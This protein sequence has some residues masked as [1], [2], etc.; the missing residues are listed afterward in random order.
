MFGRSVVLFCLAWVMLQ[1]RK[2]VVVKK[3]LRQGIKYEVSVTGQYQEVL[4]ALQLSS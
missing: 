4:I 1:A 3:N 2:I